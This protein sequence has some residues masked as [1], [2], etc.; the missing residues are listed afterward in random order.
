MNVQTIHDQMPFCGAGVRGNQA[1][2]MPRKISF[3]AL[4]AEGWTDH[5]TG[6]YI[7]VGNQRLGAMPNILKFAPFD[8]AR[9]HRE[10]GP[11]SFQGLN[12][13]HFIDAEGL[14]SGFSALGGTQIGLANLLNLGLKLWIGRGEKASS[15]TGE[16]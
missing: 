1:L 2:A 7:E 12:P 15:E 4:V 8:F 5:S 3:R 16:V 6:D 9:S 14:F 10:V 11:G 13:R